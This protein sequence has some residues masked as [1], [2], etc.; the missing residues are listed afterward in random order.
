MFGSIRKFFLG[1]FSL[2]FLGLRSKS[3]RKKHGDHY[4]AL[5]KAPQF[6]K[7]DILICR[8]FTHPPKH[9]P[10]KFDSIA[11]QLMDQISSNTK[12]DGSDNQQLF[13]KSSR[14]CFSLHEKEPFSSHEI[15][16]QLRQLSDLLN[17]IISEHTLTGNY[18]SSFLR[19]IIHNIC[20][21]L[22]VIL[23]NLDNQIRTENCHEMTLKEKS[24]I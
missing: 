10:P 16:Q 21:D 2:S 23:L 18:S 4:S 22:N 14:N 6:S 7:E 24:C 8:S 17:G 1:S 12:Q 5:K 13:L 15:I 19:E 20:L 9:L 11:D 3:G